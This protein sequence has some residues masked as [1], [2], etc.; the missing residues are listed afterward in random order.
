MN[1]TVEICSKDGAH[2]FC[3]GPRRAD[4]GKMALV[5]VVSRRGGLK[6][7]LRL[8]PGGLNAIVKLEHGDTIFFIRD[9]ALAKDAM[10]YYI[11]GQN[12]R[13]IKNGSIIGPTIAQWTSREFIHPSIQEGINIWVDRKRAIATNFVAPDPRRA[14][15]GDAKSKLAYSSENPEPKEEVHSDTRVAMYGK[16]KRAL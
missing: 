16:K 13:T 15:P 12:T 3:V 7:A 4:D 6:P 1:F 2:E 14:V 8:V 9:E 10:A 11:E 5:W